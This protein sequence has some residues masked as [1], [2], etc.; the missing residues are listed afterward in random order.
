ME[1]PNEKFKNVVEELDRFIVKWGLPHLAAV[2]DSENNL[3]SV[4][5]TDQDQ[6]REDLTED[7]IHWYKSHKAYMFDKIKKEDW[8]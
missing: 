3:R 8:N 4:V 1:K 6:D 5:I 2:F 7:L